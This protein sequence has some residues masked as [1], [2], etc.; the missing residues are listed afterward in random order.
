MAFF[1]RVLVN[2]RQLTFFIVE[3]TLDQVLSH[4]ALVLRVQLDGSHLL[5][6]TTSR[7][8]KEVQV[9]GEGHIDG[10]FQSSVAF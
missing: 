8:I 10:N 9:L 4:A 7:V 1:L 2:L 5:I 6:H 3:D